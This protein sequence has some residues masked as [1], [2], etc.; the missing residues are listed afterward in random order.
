MTKFEKVRGM[1]NIPVEE[2]HY[3]SHVLNFSEKLM[4]SFSYSEIRLPII[5]YTNL[6]ERS[7]GS[8][9]D[10]VNKEMFTFNSKSDISCFAIRR[11]I[12]D[13]HVHI[14]LVFT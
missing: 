14:Y 3:W 4:K 2:T 8:E 11:N 9:T 7:V 10:I 12:L 5:E 1:H 6:F 13:N